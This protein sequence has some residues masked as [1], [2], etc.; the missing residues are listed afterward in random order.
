M[1][2]FGREDVFCAFSFCQIKDAIRRIRDKTSSGVVSSTPKTKPSPA[3]PSKH[4]IQPGKGILSSVCV[5]LTYFS[6]KY[7]PFNIG[8]NPPANSSKP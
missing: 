6:F 3:L 2:F 8:S 1:L 7:F 4:V 5:T